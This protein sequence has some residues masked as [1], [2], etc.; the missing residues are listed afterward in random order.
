[1]LLKARLKKYGCYL[2]IASA[3]FG[4]I[5]ASAQNFTLTDRGKPIP[6]TTKSVPHIQ[7]NGEAVPEISAELLKLVSK[8]SG[9]KLQG[10][11]VGRSGSTGF[12]LDENMKLARP[13]VIVRGREFGHLHPDGS[14]H[15]SLPPKLAVLAVKTGWATHHPWANQRA[16]WEGFVMLYTPKTKNEL[17]TVYNLVVHSYN[18]VTGNTTL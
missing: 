9:V 13:D 15:I 4:S 12:W 2:I 11:I 3:L 10:T 7:I 6:L 17:K 8:I 5:Q 14:L 18:F 1:M 16:G